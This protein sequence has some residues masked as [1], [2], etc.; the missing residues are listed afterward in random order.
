MLLAVPIIAMAL[1]AVPQAIADS[2]ETVRRRIDSV[3]M[4][5]GVL[6]G[7]RYHDRRA[8]SA[9]R[10]VGAARA[11]RAAHERLAST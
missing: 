2:G 9:A 7:S 3:E 1:S 11:R 6:C 5:G 4:I 8:R 10:N